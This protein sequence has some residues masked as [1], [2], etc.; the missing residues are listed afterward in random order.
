[1]DVTW[2]LRP[3]VK[4]H[5]GAAFTSADM[6]FSFEVYKN[7]A[8][9]PTATAG[10][11]RLMESATAPD[12]LTM[13]V[14]WSQVD[15]TAP[16]ALG[17]IPLPRHLLADVYATDKEAFT[18]SSRFR[19]D[20]VGLGPYRL[21]NWELGSHME[22]GRFD[23]Y[24]GGR[25]P[26]DTVLIKFFHD[27][28]T[29]IANLLSGA[30]DVSIRPQID[31]SSAIE[32][33]D[34]WERSG[35]KAFI[36][37]SGRI[38]YGEAQRRPDFAK[39]RNGMTETLV[40]RAFMMALDR[41]LLSDTFSQG[42]AP[43]ADSY[44]APDDP[45]RP[46]VEAAIMKFPYDL[47]GANRL[48]ADAGWTRGSDGLLIHRDTGEQFEGEVWASPEAFNK[49]E[50]TVL[51]NGWNQLG[52]R[53]SVYQIPVARSNDRELAAR[54]PT[55]TVSSGQ[56]PSTW[57]TPDRLHSRFIAAP[58]NSWAGRNKFGQANAEIDGLLDRLQTTIDPRARVDLHRQL[59]AAESQDVSFFPIYWEVV[60]I[61]VAKGI[62]PSPARPISTGDFLHWVR[63]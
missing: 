11:M 23:D 5:D 13:V 16:E 37:P 28:N 10:T 20:F 6:L 8:L 30:V 53:L 33:K 57:Y 36:E 42:F 49:E 9:P 3:N 58:A 56:A 44:V 52:A 41:Q 17:L 27:A 29:I 43:L 40:R 1:M 25:P 26:L 61:F 59:V 63:E 45:L 35:H 12:D 31:L 48:L 47:A 55:F 2:K 14:H 7:P 60:P 24:Y 15:A 19:S 21:T 34:R 4:W 62:T 32:L 50:P 38:H 18:N 54:S 39:P 51:A 46:D 22:L